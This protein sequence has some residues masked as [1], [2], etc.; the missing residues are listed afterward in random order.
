M[1]RDGTYEARVELG[2]PKGTIRIEKAV[3]TKDGH[4]KPMEIL[5]SGDEAC[6]I[7]RFAISDVKV[8]ILYG[9]RLYFKIDGKPNGPIKV[10][11]RLVDA[12]EN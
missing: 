9:V 6:N 3:W 8:E 2:K 4:E 1:K 10:R 12:D 7:Y 5:E 11:V